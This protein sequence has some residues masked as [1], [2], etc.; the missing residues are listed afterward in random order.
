MNSVRVILIKDTDIQKNADLPETVEF[1]LI[2]RYIE[3]VFTADG[4]SLGASGEYNTTTN[5][6]ELFGN[7][8]STWILI[9]ES[10]HLERGGFLYH[11]WSI[12]LWKK[13]LNDKSTLNS[14]NVLRDGLPTIPNTSGYG[15]MR[16][17]LVKDQGADDRNCIIEGQPRPTI[18]LHFSQ[19]ALHDSDLTGSSSGLSFSGVG[20]ILDWSVNFNHLGDLPVDA[21]GRGHEKSDRNP[22]S[23]FFAAI[24]ALFFGSISVALLHYGVYQSRKIGGWAFCF[25]AASWP[26]CLV[27]SWFL[28]HGV[29]GWAL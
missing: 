1:K 2:R 16:P 22:I 21:R 10:E 24:L 11:N 26:F 13:W 23:K 19:L 17:V 9:W 8:N 6:S 15:Y 12:T 25:V 29:F 28:L 14:H 7:G 5:A 27:C 20:S 18:S 3:V 4:P